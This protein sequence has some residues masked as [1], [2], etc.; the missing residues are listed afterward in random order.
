LR[1][2]VPQRLGIAGALT[3]LIW[4]AALWALR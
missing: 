3:T 2:S 1:L 4:L